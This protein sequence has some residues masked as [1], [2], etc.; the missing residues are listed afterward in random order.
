MSIGVVNGP[1]IRKLIKSQEFN[2]VLNENEMLAWTSIK[3]VI[4]GLLGNK[5]SETYKDDVNLMMSAF[6]RINVNMSLKIHFLHHHLDYFNRQLSSESDEQGERYH[7][8]AMP[9]EIRYLLGIN[10]SCYKYNFNDKKIDCR[11]KG[12]RSPDAV[13]ADIC[14]W[15]KHLQMEIEEEITYRDMD[16]IPP[17]SKRLRSNINYN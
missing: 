9:F 15:S 16:M 17:S 14:W 1:D 13:L 6:A 8:V 3:N 7:Q 12:K 10:I 11:Y 2:N 5:R 4:E